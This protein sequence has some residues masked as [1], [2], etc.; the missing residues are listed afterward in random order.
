MY[1]WWFPRTTHCFDIHKVVPLKHNTFDVIKQC[2][3]S[4]NF[5]TEVE[6]KHKQVRFSLPFKAYWSRDAPPVQHST[7]VRSAHTVFM[8]FVFI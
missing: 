3:S 5:I 7:I 6:V 8:C 2:A 1:Q 4:D